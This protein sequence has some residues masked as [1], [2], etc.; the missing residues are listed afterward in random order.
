MLGHPCS[1]P[2]AASGHA[3]VPAAPAANC[4]EWEAGRAGGDGV[5]ALPW[6]WLRGRGAP[7]AA[8]GG[9]PSG[10]A[11]RGP[12]GGRPAWGSPRSPRH[13]NPPQGEGGGVRHPH[14]GTAGGVAAFPATP[15]GSAF[16]S[17][18]GGCV[19]PTG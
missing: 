19:N 2:A 10:P 5:A 4:Y 14:A 9:A 8:A 17:V 1:G 18:L 13:R 7:R 3:T 12:A 6:R 15:Y 11:R 16:G